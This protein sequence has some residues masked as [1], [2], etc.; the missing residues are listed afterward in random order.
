MS[1]N[2]IYILSISRRQIS[3]STPGCCAGNTNGSCYN[4]CE[5][6]IN[7][8]Y[9]HPLDENYHSSTFVIPVDIKYET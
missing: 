6:L 7:I 5:S 8:K 4:K 3:G 2:E 9:V 1:F